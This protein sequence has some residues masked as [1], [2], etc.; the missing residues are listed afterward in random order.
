MAVYSSSLISFFPSKFVGNFLKD[1]EIAPVAH[2]VTGINFVP[3]KFD[4]GST[5]LLI[6]FGI[7]R[8]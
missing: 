1:L 7:R 3:E 5:K 8:K 2:I 6:L 4:P